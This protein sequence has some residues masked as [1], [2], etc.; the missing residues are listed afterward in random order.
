MDTMT[1][2]AETDAEG[3]AVSVGSVSPR[4]V[5]AIGWDGTDL[6]TDATMTLVATVPLAGDAT[7]LSLAD[8][9]T[10]GLYY[11]RV[12]ETDEAG[13]DLDTTAMLIVDSLVTL[14]IAAGGSGNVATCTLYLV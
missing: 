13:A 14:T 2:Q 6:G 8:A 1:L 9:D 3:A 4:R 10:S 12:Y 7:L 5:Y 11:P